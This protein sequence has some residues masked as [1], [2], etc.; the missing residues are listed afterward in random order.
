MTEDSVDSPETAVDVLTEI[1]EQIS[2]LSRFEIADIISLGSLLVALTIGIIVLWQ[3]NLHRRTEFTLNLLLVKFNHVKI[4]TS[5]NIM[6][7][8]I[9]ARIPYHPSLL[10]RFAGKDI[11]GAEEGVDRLLSY[12]E[13]LCVAY[14]RKN[15]DRSL[16][17]M[18]LRSGLRNTYYICESYIRDRRTELNKPGLYKE[19]ELVATSFD[20]SQ[21]RG[22]T[23]T[24]LDEAAN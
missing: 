6:A 20:G 13:L 19:L 18:Q 9:E 4:F 5:Y 7:K 14:N 22:L 24:T 16:V 12:L 3:N 11:R 23:A 21:V 2:L 8:F 10:P 17:Q 1:Q 15:V